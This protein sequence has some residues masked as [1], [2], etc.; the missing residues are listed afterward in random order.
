[1]AGKTPIPKSQREISNS[2]IDPYDTGRGNPNNTSSDPRKNNQSINP[3]R[4]HQISQK[5]DTWKPLTVGIKD[6][7]E[8]IKFYFDHVIRPSVIQNGSRIAVPVI[9]GSPERWKSMQRDG[10]YRDSKGK[11]MA[12]LIMFKR[13]SIER[14]RGYSNKIDA[15]YP[16]T[17]AVSKQRYSKKNF[18]N[19][20]SVQNGYKPIQTFQAVV[21]PDYV[22]LNY[23]CIVYTYYVEQLNH[24]IEAI[25]FAADSY[26][27][28][29]ERFK[30]KAIINSYQTVTELNSGQERMVRG[31]FDIK[32]PGYI[33]PNVIQSD[34]NAL[35]KFS[36]AAKVVFDAE[37]TEALTN[38][39][40]NRFIENIDT[41]LDSSGY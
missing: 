18:Y 21:I 41:N 13:N 32:M 29:P 40:E 24:I 10:H 15:N 1:M 7:D 27:G 4:A 22:V 6:I 35:K 39:R 5:G 26:W 38:V 11:I 37:T 31:T 34:L 8:T 17:Y 33:I 9:Y 12:P 28:D 16:Q 19:N 23:N 36:S 30:F 14:I 2:Q 25:N 20:L 3:D